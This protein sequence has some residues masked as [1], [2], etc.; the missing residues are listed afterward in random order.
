MTWFNRN[1]TATITAETDTP[2]DIAPSLPPPEAEWVWV[3]GY[4]GT[5]KNM[6]CKDYQYILGA[7]H[8]LPDEEEVELC[9]NGFH[10]CLN[11]NEVFNFYP[12][13]EGNRFFK[14]QALVRK[15]DKKKYGTSDYWYAPDGSRYY[16][17][18]IYKNCCQVYYLYF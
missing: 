6:C 11:L 8:S 1:K 15:S 18:N 16:V 9:K 3:E 17:G 13:G 14:V 12:I 2:I 4:K 5:D 7:T 10:L